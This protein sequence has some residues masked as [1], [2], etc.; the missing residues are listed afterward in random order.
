[1]VNE[2]KM[3]KVIFVFS[4]EKK[5]HSDRYLSEQQAKNSDSSEPFRLRANANKLS[6]I[7][8][9]SDEQHQLEKISQVKTTGWIATWSHPSMLDRQLPKEKTMLSFKDGKYL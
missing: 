3:Y 4:S 8:L 7:W 1:M 2:Q 5:K 6:Q 9:L